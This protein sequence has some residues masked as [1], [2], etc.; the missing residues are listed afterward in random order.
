ML[1]VACD[2]SH[3]LLGFLTGFLASLLLEVL[4]VV[5]A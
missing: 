2:S 3:E 4:G 5:T 1:V